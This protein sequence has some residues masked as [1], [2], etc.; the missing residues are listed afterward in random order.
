MKILHYVGVFS[1][2]T[3]TFIYDLI[4][5][6]EESGLD[7]HIITHNRQLEEERPCKNVKVISEK[8]SF[9]KK[10]YFRLFRKWNIRNEKD[11]IRYIKNLNPD[12]IHAHFGPNGVKIYNLLKKYNLNIPLIVSFHGTD[13]TMYPLQYGK[14]KNIAQQMTNNNNITF[15]FPSNFLKQEFQKNF[16]IEANKNQIVLP[17]S[18][19][20]N[21][22]TSKQKIKQKS[23]KLKLISVGRLINWKGFESLIKAFTILNDKL[24]NVELK[25]IG[26]GIEEIN[27]NKKTF[28]IY[29][30]NIIFIEFYLGDHYCQ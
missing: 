8:A 5:N 16:K 17:N 29:Y 23:D 11:V 18:F 19:N 28:G 10:V 2:P 4:N 27:L 22:I 15:T 20:K 25:I 26:A 13:T 12:R 9:I 30:L 14:Y 3:E 1:L 21:F 24:E 7:N 6:L